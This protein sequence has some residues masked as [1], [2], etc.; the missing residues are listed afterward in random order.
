[1]VMKG[2]LRVAA[3]PFA[4]VAL[5]MSAPTTSSAACLVNAGDAVGNPVFGASVQTFINR[6]INPATTC[7]EN[8]VWSDPANFSLGSY[9]GGAEG[10]GFGYNPAVL[11][12]Y[13]G[14]V[15]GVGNANARDFYWVQDTSA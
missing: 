2:I 7:I 9:V 14:A 11:G 3:V 4:S 15:T 6:G 10:Q 1:M 12:A 5:M 8:T 13:N